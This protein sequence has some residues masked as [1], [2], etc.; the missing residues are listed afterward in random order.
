MQQLKFAKQLRSN[1]T[2]AEHLLWRHLRARRL[3]GQKFRRQ[4]PIGPY[5]VD[6][7]HFGVRL[8]VEADGGQHNESVHDFKRD[9]W[10]ESQ[11]FKILRFWNN[12]ILGNGDAVLEVILATVSA[13]SPNPSPVKGEGSKSRS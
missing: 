10:L 11:G 9:A 12:E 8:I 1:M 2:D 5:V 7:V 4:Q 3:L 6:F 13:L